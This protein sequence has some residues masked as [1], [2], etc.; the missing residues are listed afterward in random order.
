VFGTLVN[1]I[2][3]DPGPLSM[4][5]PELAARLSQCLLLQLQAEINAPDARRATPARLP[6]R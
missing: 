1:A 4:R 5:D 3:N 2:L 6:R